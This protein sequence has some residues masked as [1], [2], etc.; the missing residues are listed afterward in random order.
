[1]QK[2][3]SQRTVLIEV[4]R[5]R[6]RERE[7]KKWSALKNSDKIEW[8]TWQIKMQFIQLRVE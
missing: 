6:E 5:S 3:K 1:M 4:E 2:N 8:S 7:G